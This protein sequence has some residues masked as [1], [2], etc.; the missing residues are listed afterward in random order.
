MTDAPRIQLH[1][2]DPVTRLVL[3]RPD[4][5]NALDERMI[6]ELV[7]A[8][9]DLH[10]EPPRLLR[11]EGEGRSFCAGADIDW[12]RRSAHDGEEANRASARELARLF[13]LLDHLPCPV[14]ARVQGACIG[15]GLG[16]VATSDLVVASTPGKFASSE[17]RLGILPAVIGPHVVRRIGMSAARDLFLTGRVLGAGEARELGLV[18]RVCEPANLD[19]EVTEVE[20]ALLRGSPAAQAHIKEY[21]RELERRRHENSDLE[22]WT[23]GEIARARASGEGQSG[24]RAFLEKISPPWSPDAPGERS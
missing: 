22:S 4:R 20:E 9:E 23:A 7:V 14:V 2:H 21:L 6:G 17:V 13:R 11:L 24:L 16:L 5:H 12:M 3:S 10:R 19:Q 18:H 15:G 8:L 1:R